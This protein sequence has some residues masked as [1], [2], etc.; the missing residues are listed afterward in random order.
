MSLSLSSCFGNPLRTRNGS[1]ATGLGKT[2]QRRGTGLQDKVREGNA[3]EDKAYHDILYHTL[4]PGM[5]R[6][7]SEKNTIFRM[8]KMDYSFIFMSNPAPA[9]CVLKCY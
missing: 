9:G 5:H 4:L 6:R 1:T 3:R 2:R 8:H 7:I